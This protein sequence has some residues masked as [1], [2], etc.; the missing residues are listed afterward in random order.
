MPPPRMT[1]S[2]KLRFWSKVDKTQGR[3]PDGR[4]WMWRGCRHK[5]GY[6]ILKI[7]NRNYRAHRVSFFIANDGRCPGSNCRHT[8]D[9]PSC[10]NPLHLLPGDD[11]SNVSDRQERGRT[12]LGEENGKSVLSDRDILSIRSRHADGMSQVG[13]AREYSLNRGHMSR[14]INRILWRHI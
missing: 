3:G 14:I 4:C 12:A 8:C 13:L 11:R 9:I 5:Q 1:A 2:D 6:G 10:V 7:R